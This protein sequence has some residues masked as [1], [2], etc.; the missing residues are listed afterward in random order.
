MKS[1]HTGLVSRPKESYTFC[2]RNES[3][4]WGREDKIRGKD[5][6]IL[7]LKMCSQQ[8]VL[9][10]LYELEVL[11]LHGFLSH[12]R[13]M[14]LNIWIFQHLLAISITIQL[15][16][17]WKKKLL[18]WFPAAWW[19]GFPIAWWEFY[20]LFFIFILLQ[21]SLLFFQESDFLVQNLTFWL[22]SLFFIPFMILPYS[23]LK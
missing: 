3:R 21:S 17:P 4:S 13:P 12:M 15:W 14:T 22:P 20:F 7:L 5:R 8:S 9:Y 10:R 2:K 23:C 19:F 1:C 16:V 18:S 11:S 6:A